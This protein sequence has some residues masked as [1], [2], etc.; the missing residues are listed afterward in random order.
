MDKKAVRELIIASSMYSIGSIA[1]PLLIFGG[2]GLI[3]DKYFKTSPWALLGCI[4]IAF[5]ITNILLF[6]K[7]KKLNELMLSQAPKKLEEKELEKI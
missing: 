2:I 7:V 6:R 5:I 4:F 1:G 3:L